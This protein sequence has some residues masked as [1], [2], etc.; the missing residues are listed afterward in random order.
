M[1]RKFQVSWQLFL[2]ELLL[3]IENTPHL[4]KAAISYERKNYARS[5]ERI[6]PSSS[7]K[8]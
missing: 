2:L 4:S 3:Y 1:E 8:E 7:Q 6:R 5:V